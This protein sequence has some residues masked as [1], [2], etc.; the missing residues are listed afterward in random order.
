MGNPPSACPPTTTRRPVRRSAPRRRNLDS[1]S[2]IRQVLP[3]PRRW[4][5]GSGCG[6]LPSPPCTHGLS[7]S[8][9]VS[10][11]QTAD[12]SQIADVKIQELWGLLIEEDPLGEVPGCLRQTATPLPTAGSSLPLRVGIRQQ[13][14]EKDKVCV[15]QGLGGTVPGAGEQE[16]TVRWES[17]NRSGGWFGLVWF[18]LC[19]VQ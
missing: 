14:P 4:G 10:K 7:P 3:S 12:I 19:D 11:A 5:D 9:P 15:G 2:L 8:S 6:S 16:M 1:G 13:T 18:F 17:W